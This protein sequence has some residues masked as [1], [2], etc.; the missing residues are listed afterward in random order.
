M[1]DGVADDL[2]EAIELAEEVRSTVSIPPC[3]VGAVYLCFELARQALTVMQTGVECPAVI[4]DKFFDPL[5]ASGMVAVIVDN[6]F[7]LFE[8]SGMVLQDPVDELQQFV[9]R[10]PFVM[11]DEECVGGTGGGPPDGDGL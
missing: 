5:E 6:L 8:A 3:L 9:A 1:D 4:V 2:L 11:G 7:D 10:G